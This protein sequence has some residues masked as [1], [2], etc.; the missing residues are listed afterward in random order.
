MLLSNLFKYKESNKMTS[1]IK[2][3]YDKTV[4]TV[5]ILTS[6]VYSRVSQTIERTSKLDKAEVPHSI[7][8]ALLNAN[9]KKNNPENPVTFE[10][11]EI[12]VLIKI[13]QVNRTRVGITKSQT[14]A[15]IEYQKESNETNN[16]INAV[17]AT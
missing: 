4:D 17:P 2:K 1:F 12:P 8:A 7:I 5:E 15:L 6:S 3:S 13:K 14:T 9:S 10:E 11:N 16:E